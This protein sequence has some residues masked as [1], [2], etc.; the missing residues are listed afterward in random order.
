MILAKVGNKGSTY[1]FTILVGM[2]SS[3]HDFVGALSMILSHQLIWGGWGVCF[4]H[5]VMYLL[6][7]AV[8]L[9]VHRVTSEPFR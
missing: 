2:G 9:Q 3:W 5:H 4:Y 7:L 6:Y 8:L 1:S